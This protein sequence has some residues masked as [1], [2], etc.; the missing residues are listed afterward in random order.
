MLNGA[1]N[2]IKNRYRIVILLTFITFYSS[3]VFAQFNSEIG[4]T[5]AYIPANVTNQII[6]EYNGSGEILETMKDL[7]F[8]SGFNAGLSYRTGV[9]KVGLSWESL[10][11]RKNGVKGKL[12]E[13]DRS[14]RELYFSFNTYSFGTEIIAGRIG[15]GISMD[16]NKYTTKT[17]TAG[18]SSKIDVLRDNYY[19]NKFYLIY[20]IKGTNSLGLSIKPFI[21]I[22]WSEISMDRVSDYLDIDKNVNFKTENF[23]K[24]GLTFSILN[25]KQP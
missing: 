13:G 14:Q 4:Y 9:F 23:I 3:G 19:S 2:L 20:Y 1:V 18:V 10:N 25:G 6:R 5:I 21:Q 15:F 11:A 24:Y 7:N 17:K 22:P 8:I 16:Y 12:K